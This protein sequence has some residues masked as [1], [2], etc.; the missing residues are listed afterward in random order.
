MAA[1]DTAKKAVG[2]KAASYVQ[3]GMHVGLGTGSTA[4]WM[5]VS[6]GE[7][8]KQGLEITAVPTSQATAKLAMEYGIPLTDFSQVQQLDLTI[9]GA[10]EIDDGLHLI[11][12]GGGA[13]LRE[14]IVASAAERLIIIA[15]DSKK[16]GVL[17]EFPLPVEVVPFG[18]E[19]VAGSISALGCEPVLRTEGEERFIT[20]NGNY[21]LDCRFERIPDPAELHGQLKSLVG[22]VETGLF[23]GMADVVLLGGE[24][25][26]RLLER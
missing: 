4:Y 26:V 9:D 19:L 17:G 21:I 1:A 11:K 5:V 23:V 12:G 20:D 22:V 10:D 15:D 13:L 6:L 8:V 14:K 16:R 7:R 3:N 2:E 24:D 18:W 25:G